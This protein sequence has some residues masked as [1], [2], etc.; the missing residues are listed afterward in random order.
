MTPASRDTTAA[1]AELQLYGVALSGHCQ[2]VELMLRMLDLPYRTIDA[3]AAVRN[4]PAFLRLNPLGKI[5][6]LQQGDLVLPDSNAI[7]VYLAKHYAPG[8]HWL[9][10]EPVAAAHVQRWLSIAAGEIMYGPGTARLIALGF[11]EGDPAPAHEIAARLFAFMES[12]LKERNW[13]ATDAATIADI[14]CYAY[15]AHAPEGGISLAPYPSIK[16]WL[17]RVESLPRFKGMPASPLPAATSAAA[18]TS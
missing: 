7:L 6:V 3:P 16:A 13:L 12:H 1:T 2:R 17:Q 4:T 9:P 11:I 10:E 18:V 14:A 8:S 5:P 15:I